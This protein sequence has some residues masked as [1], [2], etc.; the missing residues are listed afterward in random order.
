M[1]TKNKTFFGFGFGAIQAGLFLYEAHLSKR[2][3]KLVV[4]EV[5]PDVVEAIRSNKGYYNLNI[6]LEGGIKHASVGPVEIFNPSIPEERKALIELAAEADE[7]STAL[8]SVAFYDAGGN[9]SPASIIAEALSLRKKQGIEKSSIIYTAENHNH[10]AEIL[11]EKLLNKSKEKNDGV[12]ENVQVLNTVIG[13]MSGVVSDD[14]QIKEQSLLPVAPALSKCFLV[15]E[16]NRILITRIALKNFERGITVF[17]EKPNLL[18]F[19]EAKLY[20]HNA[21]HA[22]IGYL[23]YL[24]HAKYMAD[25]ADDKEIIGLAREAFL[26]ESGAAL[27]SKYQGVDMLFTEQGYYEYATDLLKRMMNQHLR[28]SVARVVRDPARKLGWDDRLIGTMRLALQQNIIPYR[29][30]RGADAA[31]HMLKSTEK[32]NC[33]DEEALLK[34]WKNS[35]ASQE[36]QKKIIELIEQAKFK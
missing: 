30:A 7:L 9:S 32:I 23:A 36:E 5:M 8:P 6:A 4:A 2:F 31:L 14:Q 25:V 24:K 10:A 13:K 16:F 18:P 34:L 15:E 26:K 28:D 11:T 22:L 27:I 19:E 33:S 21:T 17:E 20:G 3:G 35:Q 1:P 12:L 29:Y